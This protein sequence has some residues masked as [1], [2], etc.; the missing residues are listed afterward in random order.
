MKNTIALRISSQG[1]P[2]PTRRHLHLVCNL[3]PPKT[4]P[5]HLLHNCF[6]LGLIH[7][8]EMCLVAT[9]ELKVLLVSTLWVAKDKVYENWFIIEMFQKMFSVEVW[10]GCFTYLVFSGR[11]ETFSQIDCVELQRW[12]QSEWGQWSSIPAVKNVL[13]ANGLL[14]SPSVRNT[15]LASSWGS[16]RGG[17]NVNAHASR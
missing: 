11:F 16:V 2:N 4:V 17:V 13:L 5:F 6:C 8:K 15:C 1:G 14:E 9:L 7:C 10:S 12:L 3:F